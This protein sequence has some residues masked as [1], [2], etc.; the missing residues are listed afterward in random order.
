VQDHRE[1]ARLLPRARVPRHPVDAPG[2][3]VERAPGLL[4]EPFAAT[5]RV[6]GVGLL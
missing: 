5:D 4:A 1:E 3:L 2:R 6:D